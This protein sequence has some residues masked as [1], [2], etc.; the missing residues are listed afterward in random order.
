MGKLIS[1]LFEPVRSWAKENQRNG[2][3][4]KETDFLARGFYWDD[5]P[6]KVDFWS[7]VNSGMQLP[8]LKEKYPHLDWGD[9]VEEKVLKVGDV[10]KWRGSIVGYYQVIKDV[11]PEMFCT[12]RKNGDIIACKTQRID[13]DKVKKEEFWEDLG[14]E[15]KKFLESLRD[16]KK[17]TAYDGVDFEPELEKPQQP[18]K[19]WEWVK[20]FEEGV[21]LEYYNEL[22][23]E[24]ILIATGTKLVS[25]FERGSEIRIKPKPKVVELYGV[26]Y[27]GWGFDEFHRIKDTHLITFELD[28]K[29]KPICDT[30]KMSEINNQKNK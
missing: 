17:L 14:A 8:E 29:G 12:I 30:I 22:Y 23:G 20:L 16:N 9:E 10:I 25:Y 21:E 7:D 11:N 27:L 18:K 3:R 26:N 6:Q 13:F 15:Q 2:V 1:E 24:W 5:T 19:L 4:D 28:E